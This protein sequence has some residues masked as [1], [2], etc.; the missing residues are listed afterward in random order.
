AVVEE[1]AGTEQAGRG[2]VRV[3]LEEPIEKLR[4]QQLLPLEQ[5]D[6][7]LQRLGLGIIGVDVE[8]RLDGGERVGDAA[9]LGEHPREGDQLGFG[10][11]PRVP[12]ALQPLEGEVLGVDLEVQVDDLP[13]HLRGAAPPALQLLEG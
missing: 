5:E 10:E 12:Q 11:Q 4:R 8:N 9:A 6:L 2:E 7:R 3:L 13:P 1:V